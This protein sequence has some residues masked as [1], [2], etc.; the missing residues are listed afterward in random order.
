MY[1]EPEFGPS[2]TE[3][4]L[5]LVPLKTELHVSEICTKY[6]QEEIHT[7]FVTIERGTKQW[8]GQT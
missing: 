3:I 6:L 4:F 1:A 7:K 8:G 5:S 2:V